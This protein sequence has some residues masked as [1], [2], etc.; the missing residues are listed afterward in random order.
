M[1]AAAVPRQSDLVQPRELLVPTDAPGVAQPGMT[2]IWWMILV[3][4]AVHGFGTE[5]GLRGQ[6]HCEGWDE[7][8]NGVDGVES[9]AYAHSTVTLFARLRGL[10]TSVPGSTAA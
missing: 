4:K 2:S 1:Q 8:G 10:S 6:G 3:I 5:A 7:M 9:R